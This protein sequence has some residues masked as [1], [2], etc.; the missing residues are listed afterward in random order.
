MFD[1]VCRA[2]ITGPRLGRVLRSLLGSLLLQ[3]CVEESS[4]PIPGNVLVGVKV[5]NASVP[6][7]SR[8][9]DGEVP[10]EGDHWDTAI[11]ARFDKADGQRHLGS[12]SQQAGPLRPGP[13]GQQRRLYPVRLGRRQDLADDLAGPP[14]RGLW[15]AHPAVASSTATRDTCA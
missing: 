10:I 8:L 5:Q 12:G 7:I 13:G 6:N 2:A 14:G 11:T 3:G 1:R 9:V 15:H 4:D